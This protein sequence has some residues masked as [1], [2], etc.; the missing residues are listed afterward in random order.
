MRDDLK[1]LKT[2]QSEGQAGFIAKDQSQIPQ[3][4]LKNLNSQIK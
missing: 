1:S 2:V 3:G 4:R